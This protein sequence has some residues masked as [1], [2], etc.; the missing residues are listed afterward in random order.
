MAS[1]TTPGAEA[2][3]QMGHIREAFPESHDGR[4]SSTTNVTTL[5]R[6]RPDVDKWQRG[7]STAPWRQL[8]EDHKVYAEVPS[9][10]IEHAGISGLCGSEEVPQ[11]VRDYGEK[12]LEEGKLREE[13]EEQKMEGNW[14][15][16]EEGACG[17]DNSP[18]CF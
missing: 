3:T 4:G 12:S 2:H 16:G 1:Q 15:Q 10:F 13:N 8:A 9:H 5:R 14:W 17:G 7:V 11:K 18:K 6:Q